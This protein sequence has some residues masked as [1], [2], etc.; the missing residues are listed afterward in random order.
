M[1]KFFAVLALAPALRANGDGVFSSR[2]L[3]NPLWDDGRAEYDVFSAEELREGVLRETETIHIV[4]KEPFNIKLRVKADVPPYFD[5]IKLNQVINVPT[6]VYA[7]HQM[8]SS[9]WAR[10]S[11]RLLKFSMSSNDSCGNTFK[12]G[13]VDGS[14]L[15]LSF[16]TYWDGEGD[17]VRK[18]KVPADLV[19]YDEL[20]FKLRTI[21]AIETPGEYPVHLFPTTIGSKLGALEPEPAT[22]RVWNAAE[23]EIKIEVR[24]AGGTDE[25]RFDR[26]FPHV[27]RFWK[28]A[29]GSTLR[30]RKSQRF[31][32]WKHGKPGDEVLLR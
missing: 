11:G 21:G 4:V 12:T 29:D 7:F 31:D 9:F 22:I 32:Y 1:W 3:Q 17:G 2:L 5:V 13:W 28:R 15:R 24:R 30:L 16:H 8:H 18:L 6:G 14:S 27:L 25:F 10:S 26:K 20:P 19:F 23:G